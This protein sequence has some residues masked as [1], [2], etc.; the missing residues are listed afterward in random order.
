MATFDSGDSINLGEFARPDVHEVVPAAVQG[1]HPV[2]TDRRKEEAIEAAGRATNQPPTSPL[3]RYM[4][5][6]RVC[7]T[8]DLPDDGRV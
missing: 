1:L 8:S 3:G 4:G 6:V 2:Q 7:P 5:K